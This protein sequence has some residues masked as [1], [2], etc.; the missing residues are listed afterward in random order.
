MQG[1]ERLRVKCKF[2]SNY[3]RFSD[4]TISVL[5]Q[6]CLDW[7]GKPDE[8]IPKAADGFKRVKPNNKAFTLKTWAKIKVHDTTDKVLRGDHHEI[9]INANRWICLLEQLPIELQMELFQEVY[10]YLKYA[11]VWPPKNKDVPLKFRNYLQ[12]YL[13]LMWPYFF[14]ANPMLKV[15]G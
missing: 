14:K 11:D 3:C 8:N 10:V 6:Q 7:K 12:G 1:F 13:Y 2:F 9:K 4:Q 15:Q 5:L